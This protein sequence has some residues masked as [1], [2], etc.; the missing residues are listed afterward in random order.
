MTKKTGEELNKLLA[1][2]RAELRHERFAAAGAR[3]KDPNL[4]K[5]LRKT[6]ARVLTETHARAKNASAA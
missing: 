6:I 1:E 3:A 5:K 2:T 4:A